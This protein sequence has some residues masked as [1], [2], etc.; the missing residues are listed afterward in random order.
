MKKLSLFLLSGLLSLLMGCES[1]VFV[2]EDGGVRRIYK[3]KYNGTGQ[4][5]FSPSSGTTY[6]YPDVSPGGDRVAYTDGQGVFIS[7]L[8][9]I[10]G[11]SQQPL[12]TPPGRKAHIKWAPK[13]E[14]V[15]YAKFDNGRASIFLSATNGIN[16]LQ[17]TFPTGSQSDGG[18]HDF[19]LSNNVQYLVYSRDGDLYS[20]FYNGTHPPTQITNTP[21]VTM[22]ETLPVVSHDNQILA[23]RVAYHLEHMPTF[24]YIQM[25]DIGTW[26]PRSAVILQP[27]VASGT[28]S[29]I[30]FSCDDK[31][32]YVAAGTSS[33][34][35]SK[36]IFSVKLDGSDQQQLTSNSVFDSNPDAIPTPCP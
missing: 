28:I 24:D 8:D 3:M 11:N 1:L 20:M 21:G 33:A 7:D 4:G 22:V 34:A 16:W 23:Y 12:A 9:D 15:G 30:A 26:T 6:S 35:E 18:G 31:R 5:L 10:G 36:E 27:P 25:V 19:Y 2:R 29:A 32:L 14:V 17:V 13:E